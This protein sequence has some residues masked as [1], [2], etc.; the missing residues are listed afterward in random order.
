MLSAK[1]VEYGRTEEIFA[2]SREGLYAQ[3]P[4]GGAF[5][6][7]PNG[8]REWRFSTP[9]DLTAT[10]AASREFSFSWTVSCVTEVSLAFVSGEGGEAPIL[11]R[12]SE[13]APEAVCFQIYA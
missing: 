8:P 11:V 7:G 9:A 2:N 5:D 4:G 1:I 13:T 6:R 3:T 12:T 10:E